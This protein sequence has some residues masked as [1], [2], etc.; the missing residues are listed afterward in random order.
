MHTNQQR[1]QGKNNKSVIKMKTKHILALIALLILAGCTPAKPSDINPH[2]G[3]EGLVIEFLDDAPP[4][5]AYEGTVYPIGMDIQNRGAED[6]ENAKVVITT[7]R[8]VFETFENS[9]QISLKGK[10]QVFPEGDKQIKLIETKTKQVI[11]SEEMDTT[12]KVD[13]CYPYRTV[14]S[15]EVCVDPD[16]MNTQDEST[17]PKLCPEE[18]RSFWNGQGAPVAIV[19]MET[20]TIPKEKGAIPVFELEVENVGD[21][22]VIRKDVYEKA[23][24]RDGITPEEVGVIDAHTIYLGHERLECTNTKL[25]I[26]QVQ[27]GNDYYE[28]ETT[29]MRCIG[30]EI[31]YTTQA[32]IGSITATLEYGYQDSV[33]IYSTILKAPI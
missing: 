20:K 16:A 7:E 17:K 11:A 28:V 2:R 24:S 12:I 6:I 27:D 22:T 25:R 10:S 33:E 9:F 23:C 26:E 5:E 8:G 3:E 15:T 30:K 4:D 21:G 19:S 13:Y 1:L 18:S 29:T 31:P 14:F 32:Y